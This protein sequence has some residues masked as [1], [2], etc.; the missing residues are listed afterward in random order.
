M[1][2]EANMFLQ[3]RKDVQMITD[4]RKIEVVVALKRQ[5]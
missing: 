3:K 2:Q 1:H 4:K 5:Q